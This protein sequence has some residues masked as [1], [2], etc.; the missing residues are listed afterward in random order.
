MTAEAWTIIGTGIAIL[1]AI[2][3]SNRSIRVEIKELRAH[4]YR[5][6]ERI[7][8]LEVHLRERLGRVEGTL[9]VIRDSMFDRHDVA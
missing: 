9:D 6:E 7:N 1:V 4:V 8:Q 3:T 5:L 2:A